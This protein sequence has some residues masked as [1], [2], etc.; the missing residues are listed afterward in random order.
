[1]KFL[2]NLLLATLLLVSVS[3]SD[4][5]DPQDGVRL[6]TDTVEIL[7]DNTAG[8]STEFTLTS[9]CG[10]SITP[11]G[12]GFEATPLE[13][14]A[15]KTIVRV[16]ASADNET[17]HRLRLGS[18][19]VRSE[20]GG[21]QIPIAIDQKAGIASRTVL[22]YMNGRSLLRPFFDNNISH[23]ARAVEQGDLGEEGRL[24]VCY[25]P[26]SISEATLLELKLDPKTRKCDI[27]TIRQYTEFDPSSA[28]SLAQV[29]GDVGRIAPARHYGLMIGSH[30]QAWI[31]AREGLRSLS[32]RPGEQIAEEDFWRPMPDAA[33]TRALGDTHHKIDIADLRDAITRQNFKFDFL[34]FDT[35]FMSNAETL[36]DLRGAVDYVIS[37]PSEIMGAGF[38]YDRILKPIYNPSIPLR[39]ALG[40]VC[41]QYWDFYQNDWNSDPLNAESSGCITLSVLAEM[42]RLAEVCRRINATFDGDYHLDR[43][44]YYEGLSAHVFFDLGHHVELSCTDPGL[45]KEFHEAL[46][47]FLPSDCRLHT[48]TFYSAYSNGRHPIGYYTGLTFSEPCAHYTSSN[49]QTAWYQATH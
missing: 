23:A 24:L 4:D 36:Y 44:Q 42:D 19:I 10:W 1:M 41:R 27:Q 15:G 26:S 3:C 46:E 43:L 20:R 18:L 9:D 6:E 8:S 11:E 29:F 33:V 22:L 30:G 13:G 28:Q 7:L 25:Q 47:A 39:E 32:L 38:P 12:S 45:K 14:S 5:K 16:T 37:S 31:P 34:L 21:R 2:K 17:T 48:D 35:C 49:R 40:E